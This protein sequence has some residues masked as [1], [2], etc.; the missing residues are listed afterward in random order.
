MGVPER[1]R[2]LEE[3]NSGLPSGIDWK[4]GAVGYIDAILDEG[5]KALERWHF[6]KPFLGESIGGGPFFGDPERPI[7]TRATF[8]EEMYPFLNVLQK[9]APPL[10]SSI[11]DVG[12]GPGWTT[13][14]LA[15][16]G[17]RVVG[18]DI[19][20]R[21]LEFAER[22]AASDPFPPY[23]QE[24][25]NVD[26]L[27]HDIE[28][29]PLSTQERFDFAIF[30]STLHHF[31]D[32]IAALEHVGCNLSDEAVLGIIEF[33][34]PPPDSADARNATEIMRRLHTLERPYTKAQMAAMLREAGFPHSVF[35]QGVNG[36][37]ETGLISEIEG[38][39]PDAFEMVLAAREELPM[40]RIHPG[41]LDPELQSREGHAVAWGSGF[42]P[43]EQDGGGTFRWCSGQGVMHL[44]SME[45]L[46]FVLRSDFPYHFRKQQRIYL[47]RDGVRA[48]DYTLA[49]GSER[50]DIV[51]QDLDGVSKL[52]WISDSRF[53]PEWLGAEDSRL[54]SFVLESRGSRSSGSRG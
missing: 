13:C 6:T 18:F 16:L 51:V 20:R 44:N 27:T 30:D 45:R 47:Y 9:L 38:W 24:S 12:C 34:A 42:Y 7:V 22:R 26:F 21:M 43:E 2:L 50:L 33:S 19:S 10:G 1:R 46:E 32:P 37:T 48:Q 11:L 4:R 54:L 14:F 53:R 28:Q 36:C 17:Y 39:N 25:L 35:L 49:P 31:L 41:Y 23:P 5:G 52:E 40:R 29:G 8:F 15:K 3:I